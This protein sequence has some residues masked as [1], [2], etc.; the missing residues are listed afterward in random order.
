MITLLDLKNFK[1]FEAFEKPVEFA[2]INLLTGSNGRG[3]SSI[4]QSILLLAQSFNG[5]NINSLCLDGKYVKLGTYSDVLKKGS[6]TNLFTIEFSSDDADENNVSFVFKQSDD[7]PRMACFESLKVKYVGVGEKEF[8]NTVGGNNDDEQT[9]VVSGSLA[10]SDIK[11][12]NQ[13]K[14]V[15]YISA[16]RQGPRNYVD[17]VDECNDDIGIHGEYVIHML[18]ERKKEI[19][20]KVTHAISEIMGGA[21]LS[22]DDVDTEYIKFL[23]DSFDDKDGFK[24][25]NVGFGYSYILP[26]VVLPQVVAEGSKL[27]IENPEAHL[28]SGAQS[29]LMD[30]LISVAKE[31][32]L[33]LFIETHSDHIVNSLRIA[34][35]KGKCESKDSMITHVYRS[36]SGAA[37]ICQIKMDREGNLSNYPQEFMDEWTK[38]MLDLV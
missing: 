16:E 21:S 31:R 19:L 15:Y 18:K 32:K 27:F 12:I 1:C 4:F 13:L 20:H 8:V 25:V 17:M 36:D 33:Q 3:K 23:I 37:S 24:P 7:K 11:V 28:H 10:T 2:Q 26:I 22:V 6:P 38:Q 5:K 35:K 14:N 30:Y 29:R 34:T 9:L